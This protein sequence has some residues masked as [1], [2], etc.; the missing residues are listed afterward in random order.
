MWEKKCLIV[1]VIIISI[2]IIIV[3]NNSIVVIHNKNKHY[4]AVLQHLLV[5]VLCEIKNQQLSFKCL[6]IL[7]VLFSTVLIP[8]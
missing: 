4:F 8:V 3:E 1:I 2:I 5:L 6:L 7:S